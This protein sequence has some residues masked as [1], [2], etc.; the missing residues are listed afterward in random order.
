MVSLTARSQTPCPY[1]EES[2]LVDQ[3]SLLHSSIESRPATV[4]RHAKT[5]ISRRRNLSV[6]EYLNRKVRNGVEGYQVPSFN[7]YI[8]EKCSQVFARSR[9][10]KETK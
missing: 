2:H 4:H 5:I 1:Y 7:S 9:I 8:D 6:D 3:S 10:A